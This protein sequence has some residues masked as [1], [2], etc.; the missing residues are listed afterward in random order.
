MRIM[1][2]IKGN[3]DSIRVIDNNAELPEFNVGDRVFFQDTLEAY[4]IIGRSWTIHHDD[5]ID[6]LIYIV[7]K[8]S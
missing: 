1:F 2:Q 4:E 5:T 7:K 8:M 3:S 6:P